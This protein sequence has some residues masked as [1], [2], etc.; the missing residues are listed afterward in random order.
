M[1]PFGLWLYNAANPKYDTIL[2][3]YMTY[4]NQMRNQSLR[5]SLFVKYGHPEYVGKSLTVDRFLH[6]VGEAPKI[7]EQGKTIASAKNM[8][9][10]MRYRGYWDAKVDYKQDI[11]TAKQK[12]QVTY[13]L[14]FNEP[15]KIKTIITLSQIAI[16]GDL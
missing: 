16:L 13:K 4:P 2:T 5:D 11:D 6:T 10:F 1:V 12:A 15:T 3:E 8:R 14:T 7:L 9:Q